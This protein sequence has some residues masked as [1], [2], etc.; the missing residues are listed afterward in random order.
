MESGGEKEKKKNRETATL[1]IGQ[2]A[3]FSTLTFI[4]IADVARVFQAYHLH[5]LECLAG[6]PALVHT[7]FCLQ[8]C[9]TR[10]KGLNA[11]TKMSPKISSNPSDRRPSDLPD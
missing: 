1:L 8:C 4:F 9:W 6:L 5:E 11:A 3:F 7:P 10:A 2:D